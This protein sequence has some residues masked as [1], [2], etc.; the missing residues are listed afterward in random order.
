MPEAGARR[1]PARGAGRAALHADGVL[2]LAAA[3]WGGGFAAQRAGMAHLGPFLFNGIRFALAALTVAPWCRLGGRQPQRRTLARGPLLAAAAVGVVLF[4]GA[5]LQQ[6]GIVSTTAGKAGFI[7][8]LYVVLVPF[9]GRLLGLRIAA[10]TWA[11]ALLAVAGLYRL[12]MAETLRLAPG[13]GLVLLGAGCWAAHVLLLGQL[14]PRLH[15]A[16]LAGVQFAC[17]ASLSL[18]AAWITGESVRLAAIAAAAVPLLYGGVVSVGVG[19][20]LQVVGQRRAPPAHAAIL[21]STETVFAALAGWLALGESLTPRELTGAMLM[22]A[23]IV[24]S[25]LGGMSP[26][27]QRRPAAP[28]T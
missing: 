4:A 22:L 20:T 6:I 2:L 3:I 15:W 1:R 17:C 8:G 16:K 11:G 27:G 7:T 13:D 5:S 21:L 25:Q 9:A 24:A 18:L 23:G 14:S 26:G 19:Y 28:A 12:S 10:T